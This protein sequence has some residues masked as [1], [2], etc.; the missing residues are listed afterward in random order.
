MGIL[1]EEVLFD[2]S[3]RVKFWESKG[4]V[5]PRNNKGIVLAGTKIMVKVTDLPLYSKARIKCKCD[6][7]GVE[8]EMNYFNYT[9]KRCKEVEW[10]CKKC[11]I[12]NFYRGEK[13]PF[14]KNELTDE[15]RG[16]RRLVPGYVDFIRKVL[17]RDNFTCIKCGT[18]RENLEV[19]HL[20]SYKD[21]PDKRVLTENGITICKNC[22]DDFHCRFG[23]GHNTKQQFLEY[24]GVKSLDLKHIE[25]SISEKR[26]IFCY[27]NKKVYDNEYEAGED[28]NIKNVGNI[29]SVCKE[30]VFREKAPYTVR[31]ANGYHFFY[32]DEYL[33]MSKEEIENKVKIINLRRKAVICL[34]TNEIFTSLR[35]AARKYNVNIDAIQRR[36]DGLKKNSVVSNIPLHWKYLE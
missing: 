19:H 22:H 10:A 17:E 2:V 27:E 24:L 20:D 23:R 36:I 7:C 13:S 21:N 35:E 25:F 8:Q 11:T 16:L 9:K 4:Y 15:E 3:S 26:K 12:E 14:Y 34:D 1:T 33:K 32:Y 28:L 31:T 29:R 6:I 18:Y 5:V 30:Y